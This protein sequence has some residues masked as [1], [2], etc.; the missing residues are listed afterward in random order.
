VTATS[1][2]KVIGRIHVQPTEQPTLR[3]PLRPDAGGACNVT[4]TMKQ[5]RVPARVQPGNTDSRRLGAHFF[6]IDY[7]R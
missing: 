2:G 1:A 7:T 3:I 4:F 5:L 6:A